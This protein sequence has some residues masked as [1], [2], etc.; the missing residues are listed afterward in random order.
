MVG[1]MTDKNPVVIKDLFNSNDFLN[2][3]KLFND[4]KSFSYEEGFSRW[5]VADG[6]IKELKN[7]AYMITPLARSLFN[8][9]SL[10]PTYA[11]FS[12]YEGINARLHK[13][14]D[15]NACT[16]TIDMC[17]YQKKSWD[18]YVEG[19][20]Y[21]LNP[22]EALAYYGNEQEHWREDFPDPENN[23]VAMIFFHFA[24]PDHW[25][26]TKGP[27][28]ISVIRNQISEEDWAKN[29]KL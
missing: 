6:Q 13:H 16:Y 26:F 23:N 17:L 4:V 11:L 29:N 8:S 14:K 2:L 7:Y 22:N 1:V 25:F 21:T 10:L 24:E 3:G 5:I 12:H 9:D 15:D 20:P 18:L 19:N 27:S 28:Y